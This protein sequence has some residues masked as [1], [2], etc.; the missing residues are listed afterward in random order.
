MWSKISK[1]C[2]QLHKNRFGHTQYKFI[3]IFEEV[4]VGADKIQVVFWSDIVTP[5]EFLQE[6]HAVMIHR[7]VDHADMVYDSCG[8]SLG[9]HLTFTWKKRTINT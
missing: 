4:R 8:V 3:L 9:N 1:E 2:E 5:P 6:K 7:T